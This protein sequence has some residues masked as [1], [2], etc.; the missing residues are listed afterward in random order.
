MRV[1][2]HLEF[3]LRMMFEAPTVAGLATCLTQ[4]QDETNAQAEVADLLVEVEN[5]SEEDAQKILSD[6]QS[7]RIS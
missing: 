1:A 5:L 2:L 4:D 6:L 3:P 7:E